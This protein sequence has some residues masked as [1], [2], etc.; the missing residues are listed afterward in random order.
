[1]SKN[2]FRSLGASSHSIE[3]GEEHDYYTTEPKALEL[4][5]ELEEFSK[6]IWE[7]ACGEGHLSEVLIEKGFNVLSS[8]LIDR[9]V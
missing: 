5:L 6:N 9:M 7:P 2:T 8:D 4:L 1:M 3:E